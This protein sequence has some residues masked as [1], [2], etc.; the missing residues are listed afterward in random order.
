MQE[1]VDRTSRWRYLGLVGILVMAGCLRWGDLTTHGLTWDELYHVAV[2]KLSFSEIGHFLYR[3]DSHPAASYMLV[4]LWLLFFPENDMAV[5][6]Y[7]WFWG[8]LGIWGSYW[9]ATDL[10]QSWRVGLVTALLTVF[11]PLLVKYHY[12][13]TMF[14]VYY[15]TVIFSWLFLLK[16]LRAARG[17]RSSSLLGIRWFWLYLL[18]TLIA[19]HL[20]AAAFL[21][22]FFEAL[23][24]VSRA[25]EINQKRLSE[26]LIT[27]LLLSLST[28]PHLL[29]YFHP[30][31]IAH[32]SEQATVRQPATL[33]YFLMGPAHFLFL[34]A[35]NHPLEADLPIGYAVIVGMGVLAGCVYLFSAFQKKHAPKDFNLLLCMGVWPLLIVYL[36]S[37]AL[38]VNI[39]QLRSLLFVV[40]PLHLAFAVWL[41]HVYRQ[42][43]H[44]LIPTALLALFVLLQTHC[45]FQG[46]LRHELWREQGLLLKKNFQPGDGLVV[47][48]N[49][50]LGILW[51]FRPQEFGWNHRE[52]SYD[53]TRENFYHMVIKNSDR[54]FFVS[55]DD[56]ISKHSTLI[57]FKRFQA[58]KKALWFVGYSAPLVSAVDCR[59]KVF[60]LN[61]DKIVRG[62]CHG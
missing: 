61:G 21:L 1:D 24:L 55:G 44:V 20:H 23:Y 39:Y 48:N 26:L 36:L 42:Y 13:S 14:G 12:L 7:A 57:A 37:K 27:G 30:W 29:H 58:S 43:C 46:P 31:H 51:Y 9:L 8:L 2:A 41:R 17:E 11:S 54:D 19:I 38:S 3:R 52:K 50:H 5:R 16:S 15:T 22:L 47:L 34:R 45:P 60:L 6:A 35:E 25:N 4:K 18:T 28:I 59:K 56:T 10:T 62:E 33:G 40:F 53:P 32:T 49:Y